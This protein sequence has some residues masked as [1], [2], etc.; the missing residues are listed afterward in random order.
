MI[1]RKAVSSERIVAMFTLD[2]ESHQDA[3]VIIFLLKDGGCVTSGRSPFIQY[4]P[5]WLIMSWF[6]GANLDDYSAHPQTI[7][8]WDIHSTRYG[9]IG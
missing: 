1:H 2:D 7:D 5:S 3:P 6:T 9:P 4:Y 8:H